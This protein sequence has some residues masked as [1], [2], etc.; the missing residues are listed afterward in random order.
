MAMQFK[1]MGTVINIDYNDAAGAADFSYVTGLPKM[2]GGIP[3][4][5]AP[6]EVL[7]RLKN[8]DIGF[9]LNF[10]G[11]FDIAAFT[12][13]QKSILDA[14]YGGFKFETALHYPQG[15][16]KVLGSLPGME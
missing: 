6:P 2:G 15:L 1:Q 10:G 5:M 4:P 13:N 3:I 14:I 7:D 8:L 16:H 9:D 12:K 11:A